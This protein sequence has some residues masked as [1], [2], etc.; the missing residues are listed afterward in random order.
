MATTKQKV[1]AKKN[2]KKAQTK[3]KSMTKRQRTLAQPQGRGRKKPGAGGEGKFYHIEV[4]PK[5]QFTSFR[6]HDVGEKGGIERVA[7]R[8]SS[9]SWDTQ[10]WLISKDF[11]HPGR[12]YLLPDHA[13][14]KEVFNQFGSKPEHV[15]GDIYKARPRQN[16]PEKD[17]PTPAMKRAQKANIKK[18][19][20]ARS[21]KV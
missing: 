19:Q 7:G 13:D 2:I 1:A 9:G 14:A 8:R 21:K 6:T 12:K 17:K 3:W 11:A 16:V 5:G 20:A 10:A 18:A 15:K 4:R